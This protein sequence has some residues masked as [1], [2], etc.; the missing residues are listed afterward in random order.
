MWQIARPDTQ[1]ARGPATAVAGGLSQLG[2]IRF[3][4]AIAVVL[5][6]EW[7]G[8]LFQ[9]GRQAVVCF[10]CISGY[11]IT[12]I[13]RRT[14]RDRPV[15]FICN[16]FLRL[17]PQYAAAL[18]LGLIALL[19]APV[20]S[21]EQAVKMPSGVWNWLLQIRII[22]LFQADGARVVP[23]AWSLDTELQFYVVIGLFAARRVWMMNVLLAGFALIGV[24]AVF[25]AMPMRFYGNPVA[26]GF[27]FLLGGMVHVMHGRLVLPPIVT[28]TAMIALL[29]NA[30]CLGPLMGTA[31]GADLLLLSAA[32]LM[33][34]VLA[35]LPTLPPFGARME[36]LA[37]WLGRLS[38]PVFLFHRALA[39][40][41]SPLSEHPGPRRFL[42]TMAA[43]LVVAAASVAFI[44]GPVR[45]LRRLVRSGEGRFDPDAVLFRPT[46]VVAT[47]V[48]LS[49]WLSMAE[50]AGFSTGSGV[51]WLAT[52]LSLV[53][54]S[55]WLRNDPKY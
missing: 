51:W 40:L 37:E 19:I 22:G 45:G 35:G 53:M 30:Y 20:G 27:V 43:S 54:L 44:D 26:M 33:A 1:P 24:A 36:A 41:L 31:Q 18:A 50:L 23:V 6:H 29:F 48:L 52:C 11:L 17:Y 2:A 16:R 49:I 38:Y 28:L 8:A 14:Y 25:Q 47:L 46:M 15:A 12:M 34:V 39:A 21:A 42:V 7:A 55:S 5:T 13:S 9:G 4:L 32:A 10:F 3:A